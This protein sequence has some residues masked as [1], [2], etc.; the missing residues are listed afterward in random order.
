MNNS[1]RKSHHNHE[2]NSE[3][4]LLCGTT[5]YVVSGEDFGP[6]HVP[7]IEK[8]IITG[9]CDEGPGYT[10]ISGDGT[11]IHTCAFGKVFSTLRAARRATTE[12]AA[13]ALKYWKSE[14]S[15]I[16]F[17]IYWLDFYTKHPNMYPVSVTE[18]TK[19]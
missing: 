1:K 11:E 12:Q 6:G 8:L 4:R 15:D 18:Y 14:Q 13:R 10:A 19:E 5:A 3:P 16:S 7:K 17:T 9:D 2:K